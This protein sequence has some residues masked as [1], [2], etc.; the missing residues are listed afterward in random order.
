M[1][2]TY[3]GDPAN[4]A[5]DEVRFLVGDIDTDNQQIN[6]AE[7]AY[8]LATWNND[9]Y[10]SAA[11]ACE[12][13]AGRFNAKADG[14]KSV[15]DLSISTRFVEQAKAYMERANNLRKTASHKYPPS[16]NWDVDGYPNTSEFSIG[17]QRNIGSG[18][19]SVPPIQN[20]P[21]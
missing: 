8:L 12:S 10:I 7:I 11:F 20:F 14:S 18:T 2:W 19:N 16:P 5:S 13:I 17:M 21:D 6:D 1:A 9:S 4:S 15:G 3:S